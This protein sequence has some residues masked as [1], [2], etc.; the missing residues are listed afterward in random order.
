MLLPVSGGMRL[1]RILVDQT[2]QKLEIHN[3]TKTCDS[4][5]EIG[6]SLILT[7]GFAVTTMK[8]RRQTLQNLQQYLQYLTQDPTCSE[9]VL[10]YVREQI[11]FLEQA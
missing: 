1:K 8:D 10:T 2:L 6:T 3:I 9:K 5:T 7:F 4:S 11:R